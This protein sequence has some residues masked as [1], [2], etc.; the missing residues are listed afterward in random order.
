VADPDRP[1]L[2]GVLLVGGASRR[3]GSPKALARL[4][5][6]TLAEIGWETLGATCDERLAFGK[7]ADRL[8]LPFEIADDGAGVRAPLAGVV[9]GLRA[10]TFDVCVVLP[11]DCPC[12][13][14]DALRRLAAACAGA[15]AAVPART[16]PLPG[17][18]RRSAAPVLERRL[19]A[20][21]LAL[22]D[23]LAELEVREVALDQALLV[24]VNLPE[25][26]E[27]LQRPATGS[28]PCGATTRS[29]SAPV[30]TSET[31]T[32]SSRSTNS[33]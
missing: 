14:P 10:A 28:S 27:A 9:A 11:V 24:N 23:A 5:G 32:S 6:R 8:E 3:F 30:P 17:A 4:D 16:R 19:E 18:Y 1:G 26:L 21:A 29:R 12:V 13:T 22:R 33:T 20:G 15:D 25:E 2:T 31:S 7:L